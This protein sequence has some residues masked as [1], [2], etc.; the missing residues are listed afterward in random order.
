MGPVRDG[1]G[2]MVGD[3]DSG[4][5]VGL[6]PDGIGL[7]VGASEGTLSPTAKISAFPVFFSQTQSLK[8]ISPPFPLYKTEAFRASRNVNPETCTWVAPPT[9]TM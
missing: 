6:V 1:I 8:V 3:D 9:I 7:I 4:L 2:L 5:L